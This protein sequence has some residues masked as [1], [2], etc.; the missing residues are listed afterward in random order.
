MA[1]PRPLV[2]ELIRGGYEVIATLEHDE[3]EKYGRLAAII[4][5][6]SG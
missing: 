5:G 6:G 2:W 1:D 4:T 3:P